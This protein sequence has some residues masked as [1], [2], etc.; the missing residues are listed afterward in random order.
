MIKLPS[1][2]ADI[3]SALNRTREGF[4]I[5][6]P[7]VVADMHANYQLSYLLG[8][9]N[10]LA[11]VLERLGSQDARL[12]VLAHREDRVRS[13]QT[14]PIRISKKLQTVLQEQHSIITKTQ[15]DLEAFYIFGTLVLNHWAS[16]VGS[17]YQ[18]Q[19]AASWRHP[20]TSLQNIVTSVAPPP[21][22]LTF[23][24]RH[25]RDMIW[26]HYNLRIYRNGFIEHLD[27]PMQRGA[28]NP[29]YQLGFSLSM[30]AAVGSVTPAEEARLHI[31][32]AHITSQFMSNI[33]ADDWRRKPRGALQIAFHHIDE[34]ALPGDRELVAEVW[35]R[36]G[37]ETVSYEVLARRL[38][39]LLASSTGTLSSHENARADNSLEQG[40]IQIPLS[41]PNVRCSNF[42]TVRGYDLHF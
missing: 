36:F 13:R 8:R 21:T 42:D 18:L 31:S 3:L 2:I 12:T 33:P 1:Q 29:V 10:D 20:Y 17:M 34:I 25:G 24:Q 30:P 40:S 27:R 22:L 4:Q 11:I 37:G 5:L 16:L 41:Q 23:I 14:T 38:I 26:L 7:I 35:R 15:L 28:T 6:S 32:I 39:N 19:G 9:L